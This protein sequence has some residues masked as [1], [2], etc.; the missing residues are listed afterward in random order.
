MLNSKQNQYSKRILVYGLE[1]GEH[2][3]QAD[4]SSKLV[5]TDKFTCKA[6]KIFELHL[7]VLSSKMDLVEIRLI[8]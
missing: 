7:K 6:Q 2:T 5:I 4:L 1:V 3:I 8:R